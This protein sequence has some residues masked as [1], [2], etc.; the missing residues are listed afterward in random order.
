MDDEIVVLARYREPAEANLVS[1]FL[2][3]HGIVTFL[4]DEH[5][6]GLVWTYSDALG[7]VK[8]MV[9]HQDAEEARNL[10]RILEQP[11][12]IESTPDPETERCPTCGS[13]D[14][15]RERVERKWGAVA[16]LSGLVVP[17]FG[18]RLRCRTC[19]HR[20]KPK[21][22]EFPDIPAYQESEDDDRP[23]QLELFAQMGRVL[24]VFVPWIAVAILALHTFRRC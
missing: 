15:G 11:A 2:E 6:V 5:T 24:G 20:W 14:L 8:V 16:L 21:Q 1:N 19:D 13:S 17:V 3:R 7:G 22:H 4:R 18:P 12:E 9:L 10:L 23:S